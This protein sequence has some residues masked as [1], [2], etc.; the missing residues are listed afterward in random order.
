ML[1]YVKSLFA[2]KFI[3]QIKK[4]KIYALAK[5]NFNLPFFEEARPDEGIILL[6]SN[7]INL[8]KAY[9]NLL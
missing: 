3:C 4:N 8:E 1:L 7:L 9:F 6:T 2:Q 5:F